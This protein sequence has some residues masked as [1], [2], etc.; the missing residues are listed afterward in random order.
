MIFEVIS[1]K[2]N[3]LLK[4][5]EIVAKVGADGPTPKRVDVVEKACA[6]LGI[7]KSQLVID[8]IY[9]RSGS[10]ECKVILK[11]YDSEDALK[12]IE[13]QPKKK[14]EKKEEGETPKEEKKEEKPAEEKK[15][16]PKEKKE[17]K[18]EEGV[19]NG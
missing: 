6:N 16:E 19:K 13:P 1:K 18:K 15:E 8:S 4:R 11:V 14:E 3:P 7:D 12:S 9:Q 5:K 10:T 17:E 2:E